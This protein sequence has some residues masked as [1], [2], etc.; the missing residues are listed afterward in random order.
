MIKVVNVKNYKEGL[1]EYIG[2]PSI[3]G[4]PFVIGKD[5]S[6][7]EVIEKYRRWLWDEFKRGGKV[8]D[9]LERLCKKVKDGNELVLMCWCWPLRCHGDVIKRCIDWMILERG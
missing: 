4:N 6:R 9:E 7:D 3:L 2:R 1:G 8:R 5:G